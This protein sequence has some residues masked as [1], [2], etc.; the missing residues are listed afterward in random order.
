[1]KAEWVTNILLPL[2][3]AVPSCVG[4]KVGWEG[5]AVASSSEM[6]EE[7]QLSQVWGHF[8]RASPPAPQICSTRIAFA[9]IH[10]QGNRRLMKVTNSLVSSHVVEDGEDGAIVTLLTGGLVGAC[11]AVCAAF[12]CD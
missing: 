4:D 3:A 1:M 5:D 12:F 10:A 2:A 11:V 9:A 6:D 7:G 8:I